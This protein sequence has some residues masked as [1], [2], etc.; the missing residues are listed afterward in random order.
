MTMGTSRPELAWLEAFIAGREYT[1]AALERHVGPL[2][3]PIDHVTEELL[4]QF[5]PYDLAEGEFRV[6]AVS[7]R[8]EVPLDT[9]EH[10]Q[11]D[12]VM[13]SF[14]LETSPLALLERRFGHGRTFAHAGSS[15][16]EFMRSSLATC[17]RRSEPTCSRR[18]SI[19]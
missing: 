7:G 4:E 6:A 1:L 16:R 5:D 12:L 8:Y 3:L 17:R 9:A 19:A 15:S 10:R 11:A 14:A 13:V 18:W 2:E